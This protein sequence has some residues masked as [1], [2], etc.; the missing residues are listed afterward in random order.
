[1]MKQDVFC[2]KTKQKEPMW[3]YPRVKAITSIAGVKG[4]SCVLL[5][6]HGAPLGFVGSNA[7]K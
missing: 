3:E 4:N 6:Q 5:G 2:S 1:M 7:H